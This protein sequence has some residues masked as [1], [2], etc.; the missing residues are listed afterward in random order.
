M[1]TKWWIAFLIGLI[2][3]T[4]VTQAQQMPTI[5]PGFHSTA[6]RIISDA[7]LTAR[8]QASQPAL[9]V[10]RD[11]FE[12]TA[13][14]L[15]AQATRTAEASTGQT[16]VPITVTRDS[17]ELT[18]TALVIEA[19]GTVQAASAQADQPSDET[20]LSSTF[21]IFGILMLIVIGMGAGYVALMRRGH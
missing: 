16:A 5:T 14:A 8:A 21:M 20:A 1:R 17:F 3:V 2:S 9:M 19:T 7:T 11:P 6:T 10:T 4:W 15:V 18:V 12:L 13:T